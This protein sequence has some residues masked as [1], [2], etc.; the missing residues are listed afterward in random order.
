VP[1]EHSK[2]LLELV[3]Q[4]RLVVIDHAGHLPHLERKELFNPL[5]LELL[6]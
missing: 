4:A 3:P 5:L 6:R 2:K 1:L